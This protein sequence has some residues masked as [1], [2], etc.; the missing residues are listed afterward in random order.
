MIATK[1]CDICDAELPPMSFNASY[2]CADVDLHETHPRHKWS[3]VRITARPE[4]TNGPGHERVDACP[5]C[6]LALCEKLVARL[7][8]RNRRERKKLDE[9]RTWRATS[10]KDESIR[11]GAD[12]GRP[13]QKQQKKE[14]E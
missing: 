10:R 1:H 9:W 4:F 8:A 11:D 2:E 5:E 7:K 6:F 3:W 13:S 12:A 14:A